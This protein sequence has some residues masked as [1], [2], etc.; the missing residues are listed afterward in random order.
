MSPQDALHWVDAY[1]VAWETNDPEQI[2]A[3][4][5]EDAIYRAT[6]FGDPIS[7]REAIVTWWLENQDEH[8]TWDFD[9]TVL[10]V[11]DDLAFVQAET[12]YT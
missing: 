8:G 10:G 9:D 6:P 3:L 4:F 5:T 11:S 1:E 2:G 12:V 7:G